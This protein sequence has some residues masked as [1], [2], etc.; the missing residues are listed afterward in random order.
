MSARWERTNAL[1]TDEVLVAVFFDR[2]GNQILFAPPYGHCRQVIIRGQASD[3]SAS[4]KFETNHLPVSQ[5]QPYEQSR[6]HGF[7]VLIPPSN[8]RYQYPPQKWHEQLVVEAAVSRAVKFPSEQESS[9]SPGYDLNLARAVMD[10]LNEAF[11]QSISLIEL[12]YQFHDQP[13]DEFSW[14][15]STPCAAMVISLE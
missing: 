5:V 1:S 3:S 12:K 2:F 11:P 4:F 10:A 13:A 7:V 8:W 6:E 14:L 15:C 9:R